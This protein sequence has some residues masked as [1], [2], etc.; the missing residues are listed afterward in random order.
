MLGISARLNLTDDETKLISSYAND[1]GRTARTAY[2]R[3]KNGLWAR[4][5][6]RSLIKAHGSFTSYQADSIINRVDQWIT[7]DE[8][9]LKCRTA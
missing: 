3:V 9:L 8:E 1:F 4:K 6:L 2:M 5:D 7:T